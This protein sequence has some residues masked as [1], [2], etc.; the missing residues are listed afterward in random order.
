MTAKLDRLFHP[1][2]SGV[3]HYSSARFKWLATQ[4]VSQL[5]A[6]DLA[7]VRA[8]KRV[9]GERALMIDYNQSLTPQDQLALPWIPDQIHWREYFLNIHLPGLEK[10]IFPSLDEEFQ[11]R[12][13]ATYTYRDLLEL[14]AAAT[15]HYRGRT[16]MRL[17]PP[18]GP[19]G[20]LQGTGQRF[21]YRDLRE[22]ALRFCLDHILYEMRN[23][24]YQGATPANAV[25]SP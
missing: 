24:A 2:A 16:A 21:T 15:K 4:F 1:H 8:A 10:W 17:L 19:D 23:S 7:A 6:D 20:E 18:P 3:N 11:A 25:V 12:P 9:L 13:R 14:F 22:R 5:R